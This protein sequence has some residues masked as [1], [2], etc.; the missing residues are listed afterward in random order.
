M[1]ALNHIWLQQHYQVLLK[2]TL[3][4]VAATPLC[5]VGIWAYKDFQF[6]NS[7]NNQIAE[8]RNPNSSALPADKPESPSLEVI[9]NSHIMG[10]YQPQADIQSNAELPQTQ[11]ELVLV[12][13]FTDSDTNKNS[14]LIAENGKPSM[15]YYVGDELPGSVMLRDIK[16]ESVALEREGKLEALYFPFHESHQNENI[17]FL[18]R[19]MAKFDGLS[20]ENN[21]NSA[22]TTINERLESLKR[23]RKSDAP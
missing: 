22:P 12:G 21:S 16:P 19:S 5:Y 1:P 13:T 3:V 6:L 17:K 15:L 10:K 20:A 23:K 7:M 4:V 14:A 11:L 2:L 9:I 18:R 8:A